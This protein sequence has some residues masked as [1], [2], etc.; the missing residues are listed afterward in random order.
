MYQVILTGGSIAEQQA[1]KNT[2][3]PT[4]TFSTKADAAVKAKRLNKLLSPGEKEYYGLR[5]KVVE[6]DD[7]SAS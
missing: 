7:S 2:P 5:Y 4:N 6:M 3:R 1:R